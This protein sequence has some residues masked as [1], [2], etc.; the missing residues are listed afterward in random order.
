MELTVLSDL[1]G[2]PNKQGLQKI[3]KR[4]IEYKML[5]NAVDIKYVEE[6]IGKT[7]KVM[8]GVCAI[9]I[10]EESFRIKHSYEYIKA[11]VS[12]SLRSQNQIGFKFKGK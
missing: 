12:T 1:L 8:K 11:Q 5:T 9:K 10:N 2:P 4:N 3:V 7:G 6:V